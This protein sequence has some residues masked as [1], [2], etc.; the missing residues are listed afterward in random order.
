MSPALR[1]GARSGGRSGGN[2]AVTAW[3]AAVG[4]LA[5][6]G[7]PRARLDALLTA[8]TRYVE[9]PAAYLYFTDEGG[10][11]FHLELA[12]APDETRIGT[13]DDAAEGGAAESAPT[14]QLELVRSAD[15]EVERIASTPAGA[16]L[17]VPLRLDRAVVGLLQVGPLPDGKAPAPLRARLGRI[18]DPAAAVAVRVNEESKLLRELATYHARESAGRSLQ[19]SAMQVERHLQLL[20][21]MAV[22][23]TGVDGGFV[24]IMDEVTRRVAVH[25]QMGLPDG[26]LD[27]ADLDPPTGLFDW[28]AAAG[29]AL[30]L[31]DFDAAAQLGIGS[32]LAVPLLEGGEALGIF[33]LV[34]FGRGAPIAIEALDLLGTFAGQAQQAL[35]NDRLFRSFAES[36]M[37]T[38][39]GLALSLDARRAHSHGHH[40]E[41]ARLAVTIAS[42][43]GTPQDELAAI[44]LAG[45]IH[46]VGLAGAVT[47][48][49]GYQADYDHPTVGSGLIEHLPLHPAVAEAIASHHEWY[50]GWGFPHGLRGDEIS[51]AGRILGAAELI[52]ELAAGDP[53]RD[54]WGPDRIAAELQQRRGS[55]LDPTVA[56]AALTLLAAGQLLLDPL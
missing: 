27:A 43:L 37:E 35:R 53:V 15:W 41:V 23:S 18:A 2:E 17:S 7:E 28:S 42:L 32:L 55:Q 45:E 46:D 6:P 38:V 16:L 3:E 13:S 51:R 20:L 9:V 25:A 40:D 26:F 30:Y 21:G 49:E 52:A 11:R 34:S 1:R 33:A 56:D 5:V 8:V 19:G 36:Y 50:D 24:G 54:P 29:G 10:R 22:A 44:R 12:H 31:N 39:R 4:A 47:G 48:T 14:P